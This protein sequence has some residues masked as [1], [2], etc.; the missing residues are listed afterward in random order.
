MSNL[1]T[2]DD[3]RKAITEGG[4]NN[5]GRS[6]EALRIK[7]SDNVETELRNALSHNME[8]VK[9]Y[10]KAFH[11]EYPSIK[12]F[13][14]Q[15]THDLVTKGYT[16]NVF[17]RKCFAEI[18]TRLHDAAYDLSFGR[19]WYRV[20][21]KK[22]EFSSKGLKLLVTRV[23]K[24]HVAEPSRKRRAK[25]ADLI[26][27]E[28]EVLYRLDVTAVEQAFESFRVSTENIESLRT[29]HLC[30]SQAVGL[31]GYSMAVNI[32]ADAQYEAEA[33][34]YESVSYHHENARSDL[35]DLFERLLPIEPADVFREQ[36]GLTDGLPAL[37]PFV[38][39]SH[40]AIKRVLIKPDVRY[41][42]SKE[43]T[44]VGFDKLRRNIISSRVSSTS[45][46]ICKIAMTRF[47]KVSKRIWKDAAV[48]PK[49][50]NCVH[51]EIAVEC[52]VTDS[53]RV[54]DILLKIMKS[55][56]TY[57]K[58]VDSENGRKLLVEIDA[59]A[60]IGHSYAA[61]KP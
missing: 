26:V 22:I 34:L 58:F 2:S 20:Y 59:E 45:M 61:A 3:V 41:S 42:H 33:L 54:H 19:K 10:L 21:G 49:I 48:R 57:E 38:M 60:K 55:K 1:N 11:K 36:A 39:I 44:Y 14:D 35:C 46:D 23:T 16:Y 47:R 17:G 12:K 37:A 5:L 27:V 43:L 31:T 15:V 9:G 40:E 56:R 7:W 50:V 18:A 24:L 53:L 32:A 25:I 28:K 8:D 30:Q 13:Q 51:D 52:R 6:D 29:V 4:E